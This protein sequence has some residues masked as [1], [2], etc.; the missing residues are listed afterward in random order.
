MTTATYTNAIDEARMR[1]RLA[2]NTFYKYLAAAAGG[3]ADLDGY[4]RAR[5]ARARAHS[6]L[7]TVKKGNQ[8]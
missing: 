2:D 3:E 1:V 4:E 5:K 7:Q 6:H 8:R